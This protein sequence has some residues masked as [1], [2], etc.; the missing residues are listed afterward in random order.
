LSSSFCRLWG[1]V[2]QLHQLTVG[3][4]L[5]HLQ[6][7]ICFLVEVANAIDVLLHFCKLLLP[8][9]L[10]FLLEHFM[11]SGQ[12]AVVGDPLRA[13]GFAGS[14]HTVASG[15]SAVGLVGVEEEREHRQTSHKQINGGSLTPSQQYQ[16]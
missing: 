3:Q 5:S 4:N 10:P 14:R 11:G 15:L 2:V 7:H 16:V 9:D 6:G 12:A 1:K 13:C 8:L